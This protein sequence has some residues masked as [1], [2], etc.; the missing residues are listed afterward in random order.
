MANSPQ[1]KKR[2][3]Q[4][5]KRQLFNARKRSSV[6]TVVKKTLKSFQANDHSTTQSAF[7][8]AIRLLDKTSRKKIIHPNKAAR[9]KSRLSQRLKTFFSSINS[10]NS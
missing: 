7:R 8:K 3:R 2:A 10:I 5:Q 6:R 9:L 1:A 4:N